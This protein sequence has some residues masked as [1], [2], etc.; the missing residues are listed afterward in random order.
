MKRPDIE[1]SMVHEMCINGGVD[2]QTRKGVFTVEITERSDTG[3]TLLATV[4]YEDP[5]MLCV[6]LMH[7]GEDI[8]PYV[9]EEF[10]NYIYRNIEKG[11]LNANGKFL[12]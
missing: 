6:S 10:L 4:T 1:A 3:L 5:Y 2:R 7:K 8:A 12:A 9:S 11:A